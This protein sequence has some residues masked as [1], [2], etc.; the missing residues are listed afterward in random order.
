M[1]SYILLLCW[2]LTGSLVS[3]QILP[4]NL[5]CVKGD[6][7]IWTLPAS[8]C[9]GAFNSYDIFVSTS[10]SGPYS[11][12]ASVTN[13]AQTTYYDANPSGI[14]RYYYMQG[15][16]NCPGQPVISSDTLDNLLPGLTPIESVSVV[17]GSVTI[18]WQ[19]NLAPEVIGYIVYR[20]T[21]IGIIPLDTVYGAL[22]YVDLASKPD[23]KS[24]SYYVLA[25]DG[26]GNTSIFDQPHHTIFM[27]ATQ[28]ACQQSITLSWNA[29]ENWPNGVGQYNI[30]LGLNGDPPV[31]VDSVDGA[32]LSYTYHNTNDG[33]VYCFKVQAIQ[34][35]T[36]IGSFSN[37]TCL[38]ASVVQPM[39]NIVLKNATVTPGN[40]VQLSWNWDTNAE[41]HQQDIIRVNS[42]DYAL[43][44]APVFPLQFQNTYLD[45][46]ATAADG[47][48]TYRIE[49]TDDCDSTAVSNLTS[50]IF[51]TATPQP[52]R[53]NLVEWTDYFN[54]KGFLIKYELY[55]V[56]SGAPTL[57]AT[58][59]ADTTFYLD[60]VDPS[61]PEQTQICYYVVAKALVALADGSLEAV[62]SRSNTACAEQMAALLLPNAFA[63]RGYNQEF[64]PK[65]VLGQQIRDY[66][67]LIFDRWGGKLFESHSIDTGWNG[68]HNG[69]EVPGGVYAYVVRL[70]QADGQVV[71]QKGTVTLVR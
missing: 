8:N 4:P 58:L 15:N 41:I 5:E 44:Q 45:A 68:K 33:D 30:W 16:Y 67:M 31:K 10:Y 36:A 27:E 29:Y 13:A 23:E 61:R 43:Q 60:Q 51:L 25:L 11:L 46:A 26:C 35:A 7:L 64:R 6:T 47:P 21:L 32:E 9:G 20:N 55:R 57:L 39:R 19:P 54:E 12:L 63:P 49:T 24:E 1:K 48:I 66:Q 38:T 17:N 14:T 53:T 50:T 28:S 65:L 62:S 40:Q 69:N 71:E 18:N 2:L 37:D 34:E 42:G 70:T 59:T 52:G 3:A 56:I 22:N